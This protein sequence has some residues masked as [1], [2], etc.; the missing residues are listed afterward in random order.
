MT[1]NNYREDQSER[2]PQV[3]PVYF[4]YTFTPLRVVMQFKSC[5]VEVYILRPTGSGI[6]DHLSQ[7]VERGFLKL[8]IPENVDEKQLLRTRDEYIAWAEGMGKKI[9]LRTVFF[10]SQNTP[11]F[12]DIS[13]SRILADIKAGLGMGGDDGPADP[14]F[15]SLLLIDL[16][17]QYDAQLQDLSTGLETAGKL[18]KALYENMIGRETGRFSDQAQPEVYGNENAQDQRVET[19]LAAWAHLFLETIQSGK[20]QMH[21]FFVTTSATVIDYL[22]DAVPEMTMLTE[23]PSIPR[24]NSNSE[25]L[26]RFQSELSEQLGILAHHPAANTMATM[27]KQPPSYQSVHTVSLTIF[28]ISGESPVTFLSRFLAPAVISSLNYNKIN[29]IPNTLIGLI[30]DKKPGPA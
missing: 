29:R 23:H 19:R 12:N 6:P 8:I 25:D 13:S 22:A 26:G 20:N 17:Q 16:A 2:L 3:Y 30:Q 27:S 28:A 10:R 5:F 14:F 7:E 18:E 11:F 1:C 9:D 24:W 4:P 15:S 21:P